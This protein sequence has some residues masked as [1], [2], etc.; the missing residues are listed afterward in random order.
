MRALRQNT[1]ARLNRRYMVMTTS[2]VASLLLVI[3]G[4][5]YWNILK[6][7]EEESRD[8]FS[9][10]SRLIELYDHPAALVAL[11]EFE[12]GGIS[13]ADQAVRKAQTAPLRQR[14]ATQNADGQRL[15]LEALAL[16]D[17]RKQGLTLGNVAETES[18]AS[19]YLQEFN[20]VGGSL[21]S[22]LKA[23]LPEPEGLLSACRQM[24][25]RTRNDVAT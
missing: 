21:Q 18:R 22:K 20:Q 24:L 14:L 9:E 12:R 8:R 5:V 2:W 25:D 11:D 17:R 3:A 7:K 23:I 10:A 19:K 13:A 16:A 4:V 1:R 15:H 6:T